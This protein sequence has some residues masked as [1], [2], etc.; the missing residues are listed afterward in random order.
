ML[1]GSSPVPVGLMFVIFAG[2]ML[3]GF[4]WIGGLSVGLIQP[5]K[6]LPALNDE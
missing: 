1:S 4:L 2:I 3:N 5:G 6:L